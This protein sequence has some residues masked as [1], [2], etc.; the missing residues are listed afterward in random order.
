MNKTL[1]IG[2]VLISFALDQVL[3][4]VGKKYCTKQQVM[5]VMATACFSNANQKRSF[6]YTKSDVYSK[7]DQYIL[8]RRLFNIGDNTTGK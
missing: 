7:H 3:A 8:W 4:D 2:L 5:R 6:F 1:I